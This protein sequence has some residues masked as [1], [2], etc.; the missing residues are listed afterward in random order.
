MKSNIKHS[1]ANNCKKKHT[2]K[3]NATR[4]HKDAHILQET[5]NSVCISLC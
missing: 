4:K 5:N 2:D 1:R 3:Q